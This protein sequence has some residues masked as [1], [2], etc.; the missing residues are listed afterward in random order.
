MLSELI[1]TFALVFVGTGAIM[2]NEITGGTISH[3]GIAT[4]FGLVVTAMIYSFGEISGA[5][6]N[7]AV[8]LAFWASGRF[9]LNRVPSYLIA[10][11]LGAVIASAC[12]FFLFPGYEG[13]FGAT[14]PSGTWQQSF[15]FELILSFLLMQVIMNVSSGSKETGIMAGLAIGVTVWMEALFAGPICGASMNPFRSLAPALV[16]GNFQF[17]WIYLIAP[18]LGCFLATLTCRVLKTKECCPIPGSNTP[19]C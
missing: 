15:V 16:S 10:Q 7:P 9:P 11:A 6:I 2:I 3:L 5:H 18:V 12:L 1:G 17:L 14:L 19:G 13:N 8:T 4:C